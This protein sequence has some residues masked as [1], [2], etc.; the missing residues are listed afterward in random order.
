M[1]LDADA[2]ALMD[3]M[4]SAGPLPWDLTPVEARK[5]ME[6][7]P[8]APMP[9]VAVANIENRTIPGPD[10]EIPVRIYTPNGA[11][12]ASGHPVLVFFHGGGWVIGS[13]DS[14]DG[15]ARALADL[16][17]CVV[18]SVDYRL[19][20][21]DRFPA[22]AED[23]YA[24]TQWTHDNAKSL[25]V[26][27]SKIAV[28]GDSA[29]GNLAAVVPL[30]ARDRGGPPLVFQL[31]VYPVTDFDRDNASMQRN[32]EG[33]FL[34]RA[35]M[36]WFDDH[37]APEAEQRNHEY[38][39]PLRAKD[40]SGLPA[41]LVITAEFDP[42]CDEGEAYAKKLEAAGVEVTYSPYDG[43]FHG[44][45][46]MVGLM[47]KAGQAQEEAAAALRGAFGS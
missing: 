9:E 6:Q 13:L 25:G 23:C 47:A 10:S 35:A 33:Y 46:G 45:F 28:G 40:A 21:E 27:A 24:A 4:L 32:G 2:K 43:V 19:A 31:L 41:A 5:Q 38:A 15:Q 34:T 8:K 17:K 42:L 7:A 1:P 30:M 3:A 22:A 26:D 14:H 20:P 37:Y 12:P 36:I 18:V 39:A 11:A 16:A 29:G 44:F